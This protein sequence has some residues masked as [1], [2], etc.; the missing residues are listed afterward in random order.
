MFYQHIHTHTH[1]HNITQAD[2]SCLRE[3]GLCLKAKLSRDDDVS[4]E[5]SFCCQVCRLTLK[6]LQVKP[7]ACMLS[8]VITL[9]N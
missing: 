9:Y 1:T 8:S 5:L 3:Y 4:T 7:S 6:S 2:A